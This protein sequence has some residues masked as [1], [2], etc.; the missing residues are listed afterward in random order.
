MAENVALW[1]LI[2]L[3]TLICSIA[4]FALG[5]WKR[6][7]ASTRSPRQTRSPEETP[8]SL[9]ARF[10]TMQADQLA[11]CS[12]LEKIHVTLAKMDQRQN[13]RAR[14]ATSVEP[15]SKADLLA[16]LGLTGKMGPQFA[17]AQLE[18]DRKQ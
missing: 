15:E 16:R 14:R 5:R 18:L 4:A 10:A 6:G 12:A 11:L 1:L 17:R 13:M 3:I 9:E 8:T 2:T 7:S